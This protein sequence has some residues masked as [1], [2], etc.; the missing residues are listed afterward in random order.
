MSITTV[1]NETESFV[2]I[3]ITKESLPLFKSMVNRAC[4][5]W[6]DAPPEIKTFADQVTNGVVYQNYYDQDSSLRQ[7]PDDLSDAPDN[8]TP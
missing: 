2:V 5:T 8:L 7:R 6:P 3:I 4:N 1:D